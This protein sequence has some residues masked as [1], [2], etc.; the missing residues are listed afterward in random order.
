MLGEIDSPN[1]LLSL[2]A[3]LVLLIIWQYYKMQ[4]MAGRIL[5]VDIFDRSS[6][7]M[8]VY[9]TYIDEQTCP[10]CSA[11]NGRVF[12]PSLIAKRGFSPLE[13][14]CSSPAPCTGI[15]VGLYGGWLEARRALE[16]LR[17]NLKKGWLTLSPPEFRGLLDGPWERSI[18]AETDRLSMYMLTAMTDENAKQDVAIGNYGYVIEHA[19]EVR[20]FALLVPAYLRITQLLVKAGRWDEAQKFIEQFEARYPTSE[21][22]QHFPS[23]KQRD[24]M[25]TAKTQ[26]LKNQLMKLSA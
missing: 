19:K 4:V 13:A 8:Y 16:Q 23:V 14:P 25:R 17:D 15:L 26:V 3:I 21:S 11:A 20:H 5:A 22:G 2:I 10:T 7:R 9:A 24:Y 12:L 18:S 1:V 6:I